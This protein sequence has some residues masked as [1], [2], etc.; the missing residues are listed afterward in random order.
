L[1]YSSNCRLSPCPSRLFSSI[2]SRAIGTT[3]GLADDGS[4]S[5]AA[6]PA[7]DAAGDGEEDDD[8]CPP[9]QNPLHHNNPDYDT[10]FPEDFAPGAEMP[11]VP[12]PPFEEEGAEGKVLAPPHIHALAD[13]IVRLNMLEVSELVKRM[14]NHFGFEDDDGGLADEG[15]GGEKEEEAAVEEKVI[16]DLKLM[17][18]EPKGKIKVIKEVR[19]MTTLGLKEAKELVESAPAVVKKDMNKEEAEELKAKLEALGATIEIV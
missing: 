15:E 3:P 11:V 2:G 10:V 14:G 17:A 12:L 13:E 5:S 6:V 7:P 4:S 1:S 16:F 8:P 18:F 19:G 9:W